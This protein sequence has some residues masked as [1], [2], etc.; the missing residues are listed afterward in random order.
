MVGD[1]L[2]FEPDPSELH[3]VKNHVP[4]FVS[5]CARVYL[6]REEEIAPA[7]ALGVQV[8]GERIV[9]DTRHVEVVS[10]GEIRD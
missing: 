2:I 7:S 1:E 6:V 10:I 3:Q 9:A 4:A 5:D 8:T